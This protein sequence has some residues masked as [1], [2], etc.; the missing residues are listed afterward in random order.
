MIL[1]VRPQFSKGRQLP[2]E[3]TF[4][5]P[6]YDSMSSP[7]FCIL[8]T[9]RIHLLIEFLHIQCKYHTIKCQIRKNYYSRVFFSPNYLIF[10]IKR[11]LN[12]S[13]LISLDT[14]RHEL[15]FIIKVYCKY[16]TYR[17]RADFP[18]VS[19]F[20]AIGTL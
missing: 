2:M 4:A 6:H 13:S 17:I 10:I 19:D 3:Y 7:Y 11:R 8:H 16:C 15:S 1:P 9:A 20:W 18:N 12:K 5:M 14:T